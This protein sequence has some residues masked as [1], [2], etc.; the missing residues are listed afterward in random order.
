MPI[1]GWSAA[2]ADPSVASRGA[3]SQTPHKTA[4]AATA[5]VARREFCL[6]MMSY[7]SCS[8]VETRAGTNR[9]GRMLS[10]QSSVGCLRPAA[11]LE[12]LTTLPKLLQDRAAG[13]LG[14][15]GCRPRSWLL[16]STDRAPPVPNNTAYI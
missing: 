6:L 16:L 12:E 1:V 5:S 9:G 3:N 8:I 7:S 11:T 14:G 10:D 2:K 15:C 13:N 4:V